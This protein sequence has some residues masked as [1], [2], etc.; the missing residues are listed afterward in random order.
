LGDFNTILYKEDRKGGTE[1]Q[2]HEVHDLSNLIDLCELQEIKWLEA[3]YSWTNKRVWSRIDRVFTNVLWYETMDY[4]QT[5]YLPCSLS[6]HNPLLIQFSSSPRPLARFHFCDMWTNHKDFGHITTSIPSTSANLPK[7]QLTLGPISCC[8][9][10][11]KCITK[12]S[13]PKDQRNS[14]LHN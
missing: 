3:Y 10:I 13:M 8:N 12:L 11:Y 1:V 2:D 4:T 14:A 6:D 5:H 7:L 9:T